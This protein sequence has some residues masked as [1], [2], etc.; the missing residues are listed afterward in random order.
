MDNALLVGISRQVTLGRELEVVANNLANLNTTGYK[1]DS[2]IFEQFL[3][4]EAS[5]EAFP[6][7]SRQIAYVQDRATWHNLSP[8]PLQRTGGPLDVAIDGNAFLVVQTAAGQRYTRNGAL[9]ISST[10]ALVTSAGDPVLGVGGPIQFQIT[11]HDIS[12]GEDG[13]ITVRE[14]ASATSDSVRGQLQLAQ[15]ANAGALQKQGANL[16]SAPAGVTSQPAPA[17]VRVVQGSIEQ[18]NV[19]AVTEMARMVEITRTYEQISSLL[20][21]ENAQRTSALDKLSAVPA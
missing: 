10:G 4:P 6:P 8:G 2:S 21:Q 14:G 9:Q 17:N 3:M 18:S 7:G 5:A 1:S 12:I 19:S 16:F 13:T 15:F 11:D 20:Q